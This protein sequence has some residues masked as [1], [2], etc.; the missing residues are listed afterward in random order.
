VSIFEY[1]PARIVKNAKV[2]VDNRELNTSFVVRAIEAYHDR[3]RDQI[4]I[5][6]LMIASNPLPSTVFDEI[7]I[8]SHQTFAEASHLITYAQRTSDNRLVIG[9]RGA[10]YSWGSK[11]N[12]SMENRKRDHQRLRELASK[13]FPIMK[14][15][16][17]PYA[18]GGAVA[19][20]RDWA[21]Y[22]RTRNS[23][24]EMGGYVG[25]GVTL[26]YLVAAA[27]ADI[28]GGRDTPRTQLPFVQWRNPLWEPEPLR[29]LAINGA[30]KIASLADREES[31]TNKP[32]MLMK[33][34]SPFL[35]H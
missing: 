28:I 30:I 14:D 1:T 3:T 13:W 25:D 4:P 17:F 12:D 27:M 35:G 34:A 26:S 33:L 7:G 32:S 19:V 10:P 11:R 22:L 18:W 8:Q 24:G 31:L 20:T 16:D 5:Y 6:S 29:W 2:Y 21:P 9:G 15:F 23:Y